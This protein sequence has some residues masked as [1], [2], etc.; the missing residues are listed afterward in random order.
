MSNFLVFSRSRCWVEDSQCEAIHTWIQQKWFHISDIFCMDVLPSSICVTIN[1]ESHN[2]CRDLYQGADTKRI[3]L[4]F[5]WEK[6]SSYY[7][8]QPS[9]L[10]TASH[11]WEN[12]A[13]SATNRHII[14]TAKPFL[15]WSWW[16]PQQ[17]CS[18]HQNQNSPQLWILFIWIYMFL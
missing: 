15:R 4:G 18:I 16:W 7:E 6:L 13:P 9:L 2:P 3:L 10:P 12:S 5:S 14:I 1:I 11:E 17:H 8:L